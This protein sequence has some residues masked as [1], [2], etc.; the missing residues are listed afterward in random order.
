MSDQGQYTIGGAE[1]PPSAYPPSKTSGFAIAS[2]V[3]S[4]TCIGSILGIIF[5]IVSLVQIGQN[6]NSKLHTREVSGVS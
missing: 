3:C 6:H 4:V 5:G 1:I 2:L